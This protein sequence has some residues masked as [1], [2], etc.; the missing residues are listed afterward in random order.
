MT[1][2]RFLH[3][4][5]IGVW[6]GAGAVTALLVRAAAADPP[7]RRAERLELVGR[8]YAWL[9]GPGA[10]LGTGSGLA[11]TMMAASAGY[12]ARLGTPA[13]AAMQ[14]LGLVAGFLEMFLTFPASQ[15]LLRAVVAAEERELAQAGERMRRRVA[16]LG[17]IALALLLISLYL[18]VIA[19]PHG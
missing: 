15:R 10:I 14:V 8:L 11:L 18:G 17:P 13:S 3:L 6:L 9:V 2:V 5:G 4:V 1:F 16:A 7:G 12:G 19:V